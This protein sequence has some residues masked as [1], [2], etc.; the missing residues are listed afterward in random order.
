MF[1]K[2]FLKAVLADEKKLLKMSELK[3]VN[4]PKYDELSVK[5][6]FPLIRTSPEVMAY[7]PDSYP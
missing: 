2:D 7:F 5:N 6:L 1:N 4:V 3:S